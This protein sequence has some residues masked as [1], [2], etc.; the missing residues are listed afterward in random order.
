MGNV[1]LDY[2]PEVCLRLFVADEKDRALIRKELFEGP[3]WVQGDLGYLTDEERFFGVS[4]RIPQRLHPELKQCAEKWS[5]CM[6][7]VPG[8]K[9]FCDSVKKAGYRIYVLSNASSSFYRYFPGFAELEYFD[10]IVVSCD[11]HV[12]KPDIRIYRHLLDIY[13]LHPEECFFLDDREENVEGARKAGMQ[14]MVFRNDFEEVKALL[15]EL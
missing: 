11:F 12:I 4:R 2:N 15:K 10:G 5:I 8:A 6:T 14:G 9:A 1:L 7:P 13:G 3:E